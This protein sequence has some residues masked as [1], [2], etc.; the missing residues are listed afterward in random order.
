ME[1]V[2]IKSE[3]FSF[4]GNYKVIIVSF[5]LK[6]FHFS[7]F[8]PLSLPW[9]YNLHLFTVSIEYKKK[10]LHFSMCKRLVCKYFFSF[11]PILNTQGSKVGYLFL[12]LSVCPYTDT[13]NSQEKKK[14]NKTKT[15]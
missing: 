10:I 15:K 4:S 3:N 13:K 12:H 7:S 2:C 6:L 9:K 5:G 8:L 11:L 1:D 14:Q